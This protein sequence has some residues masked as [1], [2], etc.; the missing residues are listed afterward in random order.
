MNAPPRIVITGTGAVCGAGRT[1]DAIWQAICAG[2]SAVAPIT[3]WD[4]G[5][6]PVRV[7]AEVK[8]V[9]PR[10]L[11]EDRRLHK[12]ISR[13]DLFGLYAAGEAIRQSGLLAHRDG[14]DEAAT[15]QFN[16]HTG[17][18]DGS[19]GGTYRSSY[20]FFPLLAQAGGDLVAFG[21]ELE[22]VVDPMWLLRHLPNNV[23][24]HVGDRKSV[25]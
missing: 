18:F 11:V 1:V 22:T 17:V 25:V 4:A 7:A 9:E 13:T 20:E 15:A 12:M 3:G 19:G 2:Q 24:C 16:D 14:L 6:W 23:L 10:A 8:G 21:R 5:P